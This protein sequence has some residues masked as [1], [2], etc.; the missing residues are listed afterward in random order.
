M[1]T[2]TVYD[3]IDDIS[4]EEI[5]EGRGETLSFAL[6]GVSYEIDLELHNAAKLRS[7]LTPWLERARRTGG[8]VSAGAKGRSTASGVDPK[9]VRAWAASS[10]ITVPAKGRVPGDVVDLYRAAGN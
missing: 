9:A 6:D 5:V 7:E 4:G 1:A 3:L 10:G 2:K 8:R